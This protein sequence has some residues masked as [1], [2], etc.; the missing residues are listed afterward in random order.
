MLF[1]FTRRLEKKSKLIHLCKETLKY[2]L[3][4]IIYKEKEWLIKR[5]NKT[6][7]SHCKVIKPHLI[8]LGISTYNFTKISDAWST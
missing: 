8:A 3:S 6:K 7:L 5:C 2:I 4:N 1:L